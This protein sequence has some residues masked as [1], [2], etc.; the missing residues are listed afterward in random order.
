M[1]K[2]GGRWAIVGVLL[3]PVV[4]VVVYLVVVGVFG[5]GENTMDQVRL[6]NARGVSLM[7]LNRF[8][9]AAQEFRKAIEIDP[10]YEYGYINLAITFFHQARYDEA[11]Q[12]LKTAEP[13]APE[14]PHLNYVLGRTNMLMGDERA[15]IGPFALVLEQDRNDAYSNY[16]LGTLYLGEGRVEE[17]SEL[18]RRTTLI[19]PAI[20]GAHYR[21]GLILLQAGDQAGGLL[22][23]QT[24]N[25]F[26]KEEP[27]RYLEEGKYALA[28]V[29]PEGPSETP[30]PGQ[31]PGVWF[32]DATLASGIR[33]VHGASA[34]PEFHP[35][36]R[37]DAYSGILHGQVAPYYGSGAAFLDFDGDG[38]LDLYI[39][40]AGPTE[41][42]SANDLYRNDGDGTFTAV[43]IVAGVGDRGQ[44]MA[45]TFGDYDN[46]D[47]IDLYVTNNGPN[48]LYRNDGDG[49]FGEVTTES[50]AGHAGFGMGAAFI[51]YDHD[52]HLDLFVANYV[53]TSDLPDGDGLQFP[54]DFPGQ[55]NALFH[56]N[57]DGTF[58]DVTAEARLDGISRSTSAVFF[59][60][61]ND[62]DVDLYLG[63]DGQPGVMYSNDRQGGFID[64]TRQA[65]LDEVGSSLAVTA[66]DYDGDG[67]MDLLVTSGARQGVALF[68]NTGGGAFA[69]D[70][71]FGKLTET[72]HAWGASFVDY[73]NDAQLDIVTV[74][75]P[76]TNGVQLY[77]NRGNG[78]FVEAAV[79]TG[80]D[81]A[82]VSNGRG[83]TLGDYDNDGDT[84]VFVIDNGAP[85]LLLRNDGGDSNRW[86]KMTTVGDGSNR[87]GLSTKVL[88]KS[89]PNWQKR[90]VAGGSG[91][92]SQ[93]SS[94]LVF[95][96]DQQQEA[97]IVYSLW[98]SG[99]GEPLSGVA[100]NQAIV[101]REQGRKSSCPLLYTW[102]GEQ[103]TFVTDFLGAG[104]IGILVGPDTYYQPDTDEYVRVDGSQLREK[105]G[106]YAIRITEQ[107]EEVP[108]L[109][110]V[111]LLVV[112]H[113]PGTEMYPNERLKMGAPFP[114]FQ[115]FL[116]K[117]DRPPVSA[118]DGEGNDLLP[119]LAELDRRYVSFRLL[120]Y[121]GISE[122][123][124][125]VLDLGDLSQAE[126]VLLLMDGWIEY[127]NSES[128]RQA[129]DDGIALQAPFLQVPDAEGN[130]MTVIEDL[131]FPAGL[132]K[133]MTV[134]LT[135]KF[136]SDDYRV[137]IATNMEIYWDRI[138]VSAYGD[139]SLARVTTLETVRADL[140]WRGY[141][142]MVL[143]DGKSPPVFLYDQPDES[144][145]WGVQAGYYTRYG[146]T[147]PLL[148][149]VDDRYVIMQHGEEIAIDFAAADV[150]PLPPGWRRDFL[151]YVDG[152]VKDM[153]PNTAF[154]TSVLPL[155]FHAMSSYPYPDGESYPGDSEHQAYQ[156]EYNTRWI[157][158]SVRD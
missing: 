88:V 57:A 46:D 123:H 81:D 97:G 80:L 26:R 113:P 78:T 60:Y 76:S 21:L 152:Y 41:E 44:G 153:W 66:G 59:D 16:Y 155:P 93:N 55:E 33:F 54:G 68:R 23:L 101:L 104:F 49:T 19:D 137:R 102:N 37:I 72:L 35:D 130:W 133:T 38:D 117:H 120:P 71:S 5:T 132:P 142:E 15:A 114:E 85:A 129:L 31:V 89:G 121:Q 32:A 94:E 119:A 1:R 34:D 106:L 2:F 95:G 87:M 99:L 126:T 20:A 12:A 79:E 65:G 145:P 3:A 83:I 82:A 11:L 143:P 148:E 128:V 111:R 43:T 40:N 25:K 150:A 74:T 22:E 92:L 28:A 73:D 9:D 86:L 118:V 110:K 50:G 62:N 69:A 84:D 51:D 151:V 63:N 154:A 10:E 157:D 125:M 144:A 14:N 67:F 61:D 64:V 70:E 96:L 6:H 127:W 58:T 107:L 131:G 52:G 138:R 13:L 156:R 24:Y 36:L 75:G 18:L 30:L 146:E 134:D 115:V 8:A 109:D 158:G 53:D 124:S 100:T 103:F 29:D 45:I 108:Y 141:P 135:G 27:S 116:T 139:S 105:D 90:E 39:V 77:R 149:E 122:S 17:A 98:P 48:V 7:R 42:R 56:N 112:D 136:L 140:R 147:A 91:Y 4:L 47:D